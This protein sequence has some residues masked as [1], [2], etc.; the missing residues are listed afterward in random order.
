MKKHDEDSNKYK[1]GIKMADIFISYAKE[2]GQEFA[3]H[4]WNMLRLT[5]FTPFFDERSIP[6][7]A[8]W[9]KKIDEE[10]VSCSRF[11]LILTN[12]VYD[13]DPV[14]Y[15]FSK[16]RMLERDG[17]IKILP[18]KLNL[19]SD[20][21][22]P[23]DI[24]KRHYTKFETK[25][26]LAR[27][28]LIQVYQEYTLTGTPIEKDIPKVGIERI[29]VSRKPVDPDDYEDLKKQLEVQIVNTT[30]GEVWLHGN[31]FRDFFGE[32]TEDWRVRHKDI[33]KKAIENGVEFR[34]L[35]LDPTSE[36][37]KERAKIEQGSEFE[38]DNKYKHSILFK[39]IE[40]VTKWL[41]KLDYPLIKVRYSDLTPMAFMIRTDEYTFIEQYHLGNLNRIKSKIRDEEKKSLC[42][43][44]YV[45]FLMV[46]NDSDI[47]QLMKS[48][49]EG[50]W[51][52]MK[53]NT[54]EKVA[55][56]IEEFKADPKS[57][58]RKQLIE[59]TTKK[60]KYLV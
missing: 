27:K 60:G 41:Q 32:D 51:E 47:A 28:V 45:P 2:D 22:I 59:Y 9:L 39:D 1:E 50:I 15:E 7:G 49:F 13:S 26:E 37:A 52:K 29:F 21:R 43:G 4:V 38:D 33:I 24:R 23:E 57:Y 11:V 12:G 54:L 31:S 14:K 3:E 58:R 18:F 25:E 40:M 36:A 20:E 42:I 44:G 8:D 19:L 34:V 35:L 56:E 5:G 30:A 6:I 48:H 53:N 17:Q 16:A 10:I 55:K 46:K